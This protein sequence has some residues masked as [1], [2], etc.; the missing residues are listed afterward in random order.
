MSYAS[1]HPVYCARKADLGCTASHPNSR[2][3]AIK[4]NEAGWFHSKVGAESWC[5]EHVPDWV[6]AWRE[7]QAARQHEVKGSFT[8]LPAVLKCAGCKLE[9]TEE[10][11][12]PDLL[13]ALRAVAFEHGKQTGHRVAVT[14]TQELAVEA[15]S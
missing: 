2:F 7:R 3:D 15:V 12:D 10:S 4:A 6:P 14:T 8:R 5:P 1:E 11:E 9:M 13:R